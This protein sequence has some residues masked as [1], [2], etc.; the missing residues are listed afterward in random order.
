MRKRLYIYIL[1]LFFLGHT[2]AFTKL[3]KKELSWSIHQEKFSDDYK[4]I[5]LSFNDATYNEFDLPVFNER[6][7]AESPDVSIK[8]KFINETYVPFTDAELK[9]INNL[10]KIIGNILIKSDVLIER[11]IP[12]VLVSFV[13]IRKNP[14]TNKLEKLVSFELS[15]EITPSYSA[16]AGKM[17]HTYAQNSVLATGKWYKIGTYYNG[18]YKITY[19]ELAKLGIEVASIDPRNIRIYGNGGRMLP[20]ANS[21]SRPDDLAENA[22]F[23]S[24]ESDGKFDAGDYILFYGQS[25]NK[26][27]YDKSSGYFNHSN[28]IYSNEVYYFLTT[29]LGAGKRVSVQTSNTSAPTNTVTTFNDF[30]YHEKDSL[31]LWKSGKQ[32]F[33]E[34]FEQINSYLFSFSFPNIDANSNIKVYTKVAGKT[35]SGN[36]VFE[37]N[38]NGNTDVITTGICSDSEAAKEGFSEIFFKPSSSIIYVNIA[39]TSSGTTGWLDY[40]EINTRRN[41]MM[42]GNQLSFRD[43]LSA[44]AGNISEFHLSASNPNLIVWDITNPLEPKAQ[45]T[46][47]N[48]GALTFRVANDSLKEFISFD[49]TFYYMASFYGS[50]P[51]QNLHSLSKIDLVIVAPQLFIGE[52]NR[53]ADFRRSNDNFSVATVTTQQI[54]NEFSSGSQDVSAIRDFVKMLY[55]KALSPEELPKYLLLFGDG[56]YDYKSRLKNNTNY[57]PAYEAAS[58][59]ITTTSYVSDDFYALM[60]DSEGMDAYGYIDVGVGRFPVTSSDEAKN[61]VDK[62]IRYSVKYNELQTAGT[63]CSSSNGISNYAEWRNILC[64]VADDDDDNIHLTQ[65][66]LMAKYVDTAYK[67]FNIEKIYFDSYKQESTP[68]GQRYPEVTNAINQRVEKGAL[69][70]NYVGHGGPIGLSHERVVEISD[71]NSW[72]NF[73]NMPVFITATCE[74]SYYDNPDQVSAGEF[75]F[76]NPAGGGVALF[77][78]TRLAYSQS[79]YVLNMNFYRNVFAKM[80]DGRYPR[81]GDAVRLAKGLSGISINNKVFTI[82]GDPSLELAMP[83]YEITTASFSDTLKALSKVTIQGDLTDTLGQPLNNFNGIIYPT[84]YD[85]YSTISTLGQDE[86]SLITSF[87]L[88]KNVLYKGKASVTNGHYKFTFVVPKDISYQYGNGKLSYYAASQNDDAKGYN[89]DIIVGGSNNNAPPD[90]AGPNINLFLNNDKFVLGGITN[91]NPILLAFLCDSNGINTVGNG[92]GHDVVATLD[93]D[94]ENSFVLNDFYEADLNS[95]QKGKVRYQFSDLPEGKHKLKLKVWDT[96]NNSSEAYTEF[97][98]A[99]SAEIKL[100]HVLN[101][102]NPFT[103]H[104]SFYFEHNQP[105]CSLNVQVKIFTVSGKLIKTIDKTVE[106]AGFRVD[107]DQIVWDGTDDYGDKIGRGVYIYH[108]KVRSNNG[109]V[110]EKY[111]KLVIL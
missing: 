5:L 109:S 66:E 101:Y 103:T 26:W 36:T 35:F 73:Y 2:Y 31:N 59:L 97:V 49:G 76:L 56:S 10:D 29:D 108:L 44:G 21:Y 88:Q 60:D 55:D 3:I 50:V 82:L 22:I 46:T 40:I 8:T 7:S 95:Y 92:I 91:E 74:F 72:K 12:Y 105:C 15:V 43:A 39:M 4:V 57:V 20:E 45:E 42:S 11:K 111:E 77:T 87:K 89:K 37:V 38:A 69:I 75:V 107:F 14:T 25:P 93:D 9:Q 81:L 90:N 34:Y 13:P 61:A 23:V 17:R 53:L 102:P 58:S 71:V 83:K 67:N 80:N 104:T 94:A 28:N 79:N 86:H 63:D 1:T 62:T 51:N 33:G 18:I 48:S 110:A 52:A 19:D 6:I 70:L 84:V 100:E 78:T 54:Y 106:T 32:W 98:V 24:G 99:K 68:G 65:T 96:Y 64:F 30:L 16:I 41:L 85:K 27:S 47:Y